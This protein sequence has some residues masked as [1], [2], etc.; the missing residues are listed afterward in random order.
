MGVPESE[1]RIRVE[2]DRIW[3]RP[4]WKKIDSWLYPDPAETVCISFLMFC[5]KYQRKINSIFI[6]DFWELLFLE[7]FLMAQFAPAPQNN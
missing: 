2:I 6:Q 5:D 3:I 7:G 1:F 4:L